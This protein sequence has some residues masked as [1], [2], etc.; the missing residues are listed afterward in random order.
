[1]S[2]AMQMSF[3]NNKNHLSIAVNFA[4]SEIGKMYG[5]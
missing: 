2:P 5:C 1:M 4:V 3:S